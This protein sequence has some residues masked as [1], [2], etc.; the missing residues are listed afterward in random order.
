MRD[1]RS[2]IVGFR[3]SSGW[4]MTIFPGSLATGPSLGPRVFSHYRCSGPSVGQPRERLVLASAARSR[5]RDSHRAIVPAYRQERRLAPGA[6]PVGWASF[7]APEDV[8][9]SP[10]MN[11]PAQPPARVPVANHGAERCNDVASDW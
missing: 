10:E 11:D 9:P 7:P 6:R 4:V 8:G 3:S 5:L 2:S 1:P